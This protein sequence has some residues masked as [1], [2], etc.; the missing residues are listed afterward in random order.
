L[1]TGNRERGE[2]RYL[3][4]IKLPYENR[5]NAHMH[6]LFSIRAINFTKAII[7]NQ[8]TYFS[9]RNKY[10]NINLQLSKDK[11]VL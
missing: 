4:K 6:L 9:N 7:I 2:T 3:Y 10:T 5:I 11:R 1:R 8:G